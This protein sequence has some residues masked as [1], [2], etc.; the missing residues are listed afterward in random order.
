MAL[1]QRAA[2]VTG[3]VPFF[4]QGVGFVLAAAGQS[5]AAREVL[6]RLGEIMAKVYVSP[7]FTALIHFRLGESDKGFEWVDKAF[8]DGDHWLEYVKVFPGF[9]GIRGDPRYTAL[10]GKLRL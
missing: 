4:L 5:Q 1:A 7:F 6:A 3:N 8:E 10:L 2:K 9:D